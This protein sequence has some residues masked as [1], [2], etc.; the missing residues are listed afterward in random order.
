MSEAHMRYLGD[1]KF[2]AVARVDREIADDMA[3]PGQIVTVKL[4]RKRSNQQNAYFHAIIAAAFDNQTAGHLH[5][6]PPHLKAWLL[7]E[8][9]HCDEYR[10]PLGSLLPSDVQSVVGTLAAALKLNCDTMVSSY[11]RRKHEM[12]LRVARSWSFR[13]LGPERAGEILDAVIGLIC[14]QICPGMS[15]ADLKRNAS[16]AVKPRGTVAA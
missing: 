11:D 1:G 4:A 15:V 16:D 12:V 7:C 9:G 8:A 10:V 3:D 2:A 5:P 6:S 13:K 14:T